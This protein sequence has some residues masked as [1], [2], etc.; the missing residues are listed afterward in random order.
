MWWCCR[1]LSFLYPA[2][3][4]SVS[5]YCRLLSFC[6]R[7]QPAPCRGAVVYSRFASGSS[8]LCVL[9]LSF[10]LILC[11]APAGSV[12]WC[13]R[14]LSFCVQF[15]P[16]LCR[17]AVV[18]SGFASG[19]SPLCVVV[20]SFIIVLRPA[21]AGSVSWCGCLLLFCV[22]L[23]PALC[24]G[25]VV[26]SRLAS[27]SSP[28][29]VV[30]LSFTLVWHPAPA[31]SVSWCCRL[32]SFCVRIQP[33]LCC[34]AVVYSCFASGSSRLCVVVLLFT[35]VLC[36]APAGSMSWCCRLLSSWYYRL[37]SSCGQLQPALCRSAVL[38]SR[39]VSGSSRLCVVVLLFTLVLRPAP[40][41]SVSWCCRLLSFCFRLE[42][43]LCRGTVVYSRF[44][45]SS[46]LLCVVVLL[47]TL[48]LCPAQA[49]S[50]SRRCH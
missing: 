40:A 11:I 50:V 25:T 19:S 5:W 38:Y 13:C 7:L 33:A 41:G 8:R 22:R 18:Y 20:L 2:P 14:L 30:V 36:L 43:A 21:P 28:L 10:T 27:G 39:V 35:L 15:Q 16:A 44:A 29:C 1:L 4:R 37:L 32:L 48:V 26:H 12:S 45:V 46:S 6:V 9:A 34:G 49:S 17:G 23:Q 3:A 31:R 24:R 42:P 47:F